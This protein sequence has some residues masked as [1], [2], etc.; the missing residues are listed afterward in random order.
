MVKTRRHLPRAGLFLPLFMGIFLLAARP[1]TAQFSEAVLAG[2]G[3]TNYTGYVIDADQAAREI[4]RGIEA[5][6]FEIAFPMRFALILKLMR[7]LPYRLYFPLIRRA[8]GK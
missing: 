3:V 1:V 8:T 6:R 2:S 5:G 7:L 4:V